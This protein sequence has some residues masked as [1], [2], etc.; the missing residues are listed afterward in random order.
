MDFHTNKI[1]PSEHPLAPTCIILHYSRYT[2]RH[3]NIIRGTLNKLSCYPICSDFRSVIFPGEYD[4]ERLTRENSVLGSR[5]TSLT[6]TNRVAE[7]NIDHS[8][9][10]TERQ[11]SNNIMVHAECPT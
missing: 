3:I 7:Y 4:A 10:V 9:Y 11:N 8:N 5:T 2:R 1:T 6:T